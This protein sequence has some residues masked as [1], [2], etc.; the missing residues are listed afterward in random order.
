MSDCPRSRI[1]EIN[2]ALISRLVRQGHAWFCQ[3][4]Y[5]SGTPSIKPQGRSLVVPLLTQIK[6]FKVLPITLGRKD[7]EMSETQ[8]FK[9]FRI[10]AAV[11]TAVLY[12]FLAATGNA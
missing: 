3:A 10:W 8:Q 4:A 5:S 1:K 11:G 12:V 2:S 6:V 9:N 7:N